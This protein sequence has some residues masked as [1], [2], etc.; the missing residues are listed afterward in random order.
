MMR[1]KKR[2]CVDCETSEVIY[3]VRLQHIQIDKELCVMCLKGRAQLQNMKEDKLPF[4]KLLAKIQGETAKRVH[5]EIKNSS[6]VNRLGRYKGITHY[7]KLSQYWIE[8]I[9]Y[10]QKDA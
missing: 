2:L 8:Q 1:S 3:K 4:P 7:S 5:S 9:A 10:V 6:V